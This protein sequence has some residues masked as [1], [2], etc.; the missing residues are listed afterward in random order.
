MRLNT[1]FRQRIVKIIWIVRIGLAMQ[2][3][4]VIVLIVVNVEG[5]AKVIRLRSERENSIKMTS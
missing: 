1:G 4:M 3:E 2:G 5:I